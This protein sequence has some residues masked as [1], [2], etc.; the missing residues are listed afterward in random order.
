MRGDHRSALSTLLGAWVG[1]S[2]LALGCG[3]GGPTA[4]V[5]TP[6]PTTIDG[7]AISGTYAVR[8]ITVQ[9]T[10][11][12]QREI[13]GTLDL[14]ASDVRYSVRFELETTAPDLEGNVPVRVV[15]TGTGF[16]VGDVLTGTT[17]EW[18]TLVPPEGGLGEV[19][20]GDAALPTNA[21][22]KIVSTSRASFDE[23]GAFEI[24]LQNYPAAGEDYEPSMTVLAGRR[25][26]DATG[27]PAGSR[28]R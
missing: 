17:E 28:S 10:S 22:R 16:L 3:D 1:A 7:S 24:V 25:I 21:G 18:M 6:P 26:A 19:E 11:G 27:S 9:A 14:D 15:G 5:S 20:I 2:M 12:R 4:A 23:D 8:G 13:D